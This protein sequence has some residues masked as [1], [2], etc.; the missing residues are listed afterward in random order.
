MA[1]AQMNFIFIFLFLFS[2]STYSADCSQDTSICSFYCQKSQE[3]GCQKNNYLTSFGHKYCQLFIKKEKSYSPPAHKTLAH[4][5][6][7]LV[8]HLAHR[9]SLTCQ[10]VGRI[11]ISSH[12]DCY[13]DNDF[14][15]LGTKDKLTTLWF[16]RSELFDPLFQSTM[17]K[18]VSRCDQRKKNH[19][20]DFKR[21]EIRKN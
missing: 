18:I 20:V 2:A 5:R 9:S 12:I 4:I 6:S 21:N 13:V 11:A 17:R 15:E 16:I 14:C 8:N 3:L 7:C 1:M 19:P 10:N